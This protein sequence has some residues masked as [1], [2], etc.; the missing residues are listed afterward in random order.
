MNKIINDPAQYG[1]KGQPWNKEFVDYMVAIATHPNFKGMPD[2]VKDDGKIQWEAPS[3]RSSGKY[4]YTHQ[5]RLNWW[6]EKAKDLGIQPDSNQWI[7]KTAKAIHPFGSKPCKRCGQSMEISYC[8]PNGNFRRRLTKLTKGHMECGQVENLEGLISRMVDV[9]GL[10]SLNLVPRLLETGNIKPPAHGENLETWLQ[11]IRED[12]I[13]SEPSMLSPGAMSNAPDRFDGFH[14]FNLCCRKRA[15]SGRHDANMRS[16]STDRRV[17]EYWSE[18]NWI[19]ANRMMGLVNSKFRDEPSADGGE[20]PPSADHI[21]P[22]SLGFSHRPEFR[23]LSQAA[24]SAKNN[25]MTLW[26]VEHLRESESLGGEVASWYAKPLWDLRKD[27]VESDETALRLSKLM[28][29][30]QRNAMRLLACL[31]KA[32]S[33]AF[34]ASL[35]EL[36]FADY[37]FEFEGLVVEDYVTKYDRVSES[38]RETKYAEEQKARRLRVGFDALKDYSD[39]DNRHT[40]FV[41]E[42]EVQAQLEKA[43]KTLESVSPEIQEINQQMNI[44]LASTEEVANDSRLRLLSS[45]VPKKSNPIFR[46]AMGHLL[47]AMEC[48]GQNLSQLWDNERYVRAEQDVD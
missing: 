13:P 7:S 9:L 33:F 22:I 37:D 3:N 46:E 39:K 41:G 34:L 29:D 11:W 44:L 43:L 18:G 23:L 10:N 38:P 47:Q 6:R 25:R 2:A 12:Y 19:A 17:F 16:Y 40:F 27:S 1:S 30:N 24:N 26:D 5:S 35:L 42:R 45:R 20:G 4:Q 14:S 15:D 32:G 28:R 48:V 21:G 36:E 8:Y 31:H